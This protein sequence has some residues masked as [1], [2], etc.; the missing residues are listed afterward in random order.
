MFL[1]LNFNMESHYI[2]LELKLSLGI[3][4]KEEAGF[5]CVEQLESNESEFEGCWGPRIQPQ[6]R[7]TARQSLGSQ[8]NLTHV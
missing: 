1:Q 7:R 4:Y 3:K 5:T 2:I 8:L 6:N